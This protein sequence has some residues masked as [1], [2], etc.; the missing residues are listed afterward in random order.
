MIY[1]FKYFIKYWYFY[2]FYLENILDSA[3]L[4]LDPMSEV[5][6]LHVRGQE[7]VLHIRGLAQ[8]PQGGRGFLV[9][10]NGEGFGKV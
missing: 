10:D 3:V 7:L 9:R 2:A 4:V 8:V 5:V 6:L 1:S